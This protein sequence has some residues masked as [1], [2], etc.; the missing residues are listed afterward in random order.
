MIVKL[1][2]KVC[3]H[4]RITYNQN[5]GINHLRKARID[6]I[7]IPRSVALKERRVH[8]LLSHHTKI[9][10]FCEFNRINHSDE[11]QVVD[12]VTFIS[13]TVITVL[14]L[15]DWLMIELRPHALKFSSLKLI[16]LI[17]VRIRIDV[18]AYKFSFWKQS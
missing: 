9:S 17:T 10:G 4:K 6:E 8:C 11:K 14:R 13:M 3:H 7:I 12:V 15:I 2:H 1:L 5:G 18:S 16:D